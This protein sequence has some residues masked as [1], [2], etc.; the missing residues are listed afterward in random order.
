MW[1]VKKVMSE[2]DKGQLKGWVNDASQIARDN[3]LKKAADDAIAKAN[4]KAS[5]YGGLMRGFVG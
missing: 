2:L 4:A 1:K 3:A 5:S